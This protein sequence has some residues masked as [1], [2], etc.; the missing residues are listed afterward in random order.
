MFIQIL[1]SV[2][3]SEI[4]KNLKEIKRDD[5]FIYKKA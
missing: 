3:P 2:L 1:K 4:F 5:W